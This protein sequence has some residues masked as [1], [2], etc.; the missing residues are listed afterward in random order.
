MIAYPRVL[1]PAAEKAGIKIPPDPNEFDSEEYPH[2]HV[3]CIM[4]LG[5]PMPYWGVIWD[6][7]QVVAD[8]NDEE[9]LEITAQQL[10]D[11]GFQIG[12]PI[13]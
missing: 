8:C 9:I 12:K 3:L 6:N 11:R 1:V 5:S 7:A 4:Q 10:I 2:F 13:P